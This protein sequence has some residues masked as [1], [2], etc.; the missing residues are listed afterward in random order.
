MLL[1]LL[2]LLLLHPQLCS[3]TTLGRNPNEKNGVETPRVGRRGDKP[4]KRRQLLHCE[5]E[6]EG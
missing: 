2:L 5:R 1:L 4:R 6:R 3:I